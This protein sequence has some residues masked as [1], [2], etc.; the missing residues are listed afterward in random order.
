MFSL[1][2]SAQ[3]SPTLSALKKVETLALSAGFLTFFWSEGGITL[4]DSDRVGPVRDD[5][6]FQLARAHAW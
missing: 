2:L 6:S 1:P 4:P 5:A 3:D